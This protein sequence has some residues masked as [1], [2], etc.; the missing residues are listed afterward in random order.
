MMFAAHAVASHHAAMECFRRAML[1][2]NEC[3]QAGRA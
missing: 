3:G 2:A 1:A